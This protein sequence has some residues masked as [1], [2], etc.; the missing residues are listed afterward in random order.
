MFTSSGIGFHRVKLTEARIVR[1]TQ[2]FI[3]AGHYGSGK[4]EFCVNF[5]QRMRRKGLETAIADLDI[6]NPYFRSRE[7]QNAFSRIG[8]Q[9]VSSNFSDDAYLD[10]PAMSS[11]IQ[12]FFY[13][14]HRVNICDV[15]GDAV[16]ARV[17]SV[18][19]DQIRSTD[20]ALWIVVNANRYLTQTAQ[21]VLDYIRD[22]ENASGLTATGIVNN[23]HMMKETTV[24]DVVKGDIL[25]RE[26]SELS[27]IPIRCTCFR[28]C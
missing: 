6:V 24:E 25:C 8:V 20:Y 10:T 26:V 21:D 22:I 23:T 14:N 9:I 27:G 16:G 15:G 28:I 12:S 13:D 19:R 5:A 1:K 18:Y 2:L 3:V 17:L 11:E 4:T 7:L